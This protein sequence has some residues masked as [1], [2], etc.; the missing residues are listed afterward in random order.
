MEKIR[1]DPKAKYCLTQIVNEGLM[2]EG[3]SYFKC[4]NII[5]EELWAK[6]ADRI[7]KPFKTGNGKGTSYFVKGKN[8]IAFLEKQESK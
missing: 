5:I 4:K 8:L 7:L 3:K 1:I 6:P 2:G